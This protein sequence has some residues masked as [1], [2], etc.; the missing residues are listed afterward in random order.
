M[1]FTELMREI[2]PHFQKFYQNPA[3]FIKNPGFVD[4]KASLSNT[5]LILPVFN[6]PKYFSYLCQYLALTCEKTELIVIDAGDA[7][8]S[9]LHRAE[10]DELK[11][12]SPSLEII[13]EHHPGI[14]P[15]EQLMRAAQVATNKFVI[16]CPDDDFVL[17]SALKGMEQKLER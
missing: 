7:E 5:S 10:L 1:K 15:V 14:S 3:F 16:R 11:K 12:V 13:Y 2:V 8:N 17:L 4:K 9:V 6:R